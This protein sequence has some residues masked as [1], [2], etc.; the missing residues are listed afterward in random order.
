MRGGQGGELRVGELQAPPDLVGVLE[1]DRRPRGVRR[2]PARP[3]SRSNT[4]TPISV[5]SNAIWCDTDGWE[6][7][8]VP[9]ARE[10]DRSWAT[11][12]NTIRRRG[13]IDNFYHYE[14]ICI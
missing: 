11:A 1:Q 10:N 13:S 6:S 5:S 3:R 9:A 4:R 14:K 8:S 12:R 2:S 7:E